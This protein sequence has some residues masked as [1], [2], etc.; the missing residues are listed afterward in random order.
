MNL[1]NLLQ[2]PVAKS[3]IISTEKYWLTYNILMY[4]ILQW[5]GIRVFFTEQNQSYFDPKLAAVTEYLI[6]MRYPVEQ[7]MKQ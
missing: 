3:M 4:S 1:S 2:L 6:A 5:I 7:L